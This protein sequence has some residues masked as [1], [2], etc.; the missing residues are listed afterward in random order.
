MAN[1][2]QERACDLCNRKTWWYGDHC[3]NHS[4]WK[5]G[6]KHAVPDVMVLM[7][8]RDTPKE[9]TEEEFRRMNRMDR[10]VMNFAGD[11]RAQVA[12]SQELTDA[13][14]GKDDGVPFDLDKTYCSYCG[15]PVEQID[16]T[17]S[18]IKP[19]IRFSS[20][21]YMDPD[22]HEIKELRKINVISET[23]HACPKCCLNIRK[24]IIVQRV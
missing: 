7:K 24:P 23:L 12:V 9:P 21:P 3:T 8:L 17:T 22:T 20:E 4:V 14:F 19:H 5:P 1:K 13:V 16:L 2:F 10:K 15:S 18:K 6:V 11:K